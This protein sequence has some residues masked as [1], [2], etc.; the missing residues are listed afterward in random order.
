MKTQQGHLLL[1][2]LIFIHCYSLAATES[3]FYVAAPQLDSNEMKTGIT[4]HSAKGT[5]KKILSVKG[6][7]A[8]FKKLSL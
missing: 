4:V 8:I 5:I 6:F 1:L 2:I 7:R 3:L